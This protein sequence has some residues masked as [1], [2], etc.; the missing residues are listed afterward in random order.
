MK[1]QTE[2]E[3]EMT[4]EPGVEVGLEIPEGQGVGVGE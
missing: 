4:E 2:L 3:E 1:V